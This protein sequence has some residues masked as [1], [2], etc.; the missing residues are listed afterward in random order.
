VHA[1]PPRRRAARRAARQRALPALPDALL[2]TPAAK[3]VPLLDRD[4]EAIVTL[5]RKLG[6]DGEH[7]PDDVLVARYAGAQ[8]RAQESSG[9]PFPRR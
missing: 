9:G 4:G 3:R 2:V 5:S 7:L 1:T 6:P 8:G